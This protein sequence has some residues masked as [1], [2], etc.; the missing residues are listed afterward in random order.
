MV[1]LIVQTAVTLKHKIEIPEPIMCRLAGGALA[2]KV[3]RGGALV[4]EHAQSVLDLA[5]LHMPIAGMRGRVVVAVIDQR[6]ECQF[7]GRSAAYEFIPDV[8]RVRPLLH[9][10]ALIEKR[11]WMEQGSNTTYVRYELVRGRA[12][13][14]LTLKAL[15]NYR[16]YHSTTHAGDWHMEV[17]QVESGLRV[18]AYEGATP[19]YLLS[20]RATG[21]SVHD[22]FRN[23]D[24]VLE[25][26]RGLDDHE[27]HLHAGTFRD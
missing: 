5:D 10:D 23:F 15:V 1:L 18:L 24:L 26:Y 17:S 11:I 16:D 27:D 21:E 3:E 19:F 14:E 20:Q 8:G 9:P 4:S 13:V 22:W 6:L 2:K 7:D 25:R 12:P